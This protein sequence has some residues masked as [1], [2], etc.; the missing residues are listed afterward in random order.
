MKKKI[1]AVALFCFVIDIISKYLVVSF[2]DSEF[3]IIKNFFS[4]Y[5]TKN[6]GAA[7]SM[8]SGNAIFLALI[9]I[10]VI[11][12]LHKYVFKDV[13]RCYEVLAY[14]M[15]VGG[16]LGNLVERI[17]YM[18]VT[19]FFKFNIFGYNF[20]IFNV[21]DIFICVGGFLLILDVVRSELNEYKSRKR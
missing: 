12:L 10:V 14:G 5:Y 3:V 1:Y 11:F 17:I 2:L 18:G 21:A 8:F 6:T 9:G 20:P 4:L 16:I 13:T 15:L 7:F 19:D